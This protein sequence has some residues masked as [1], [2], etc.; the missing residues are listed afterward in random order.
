MVLRRGD[1]GKES[2]SPRGIVST[3]PQ[4]VVGRRPIPFRNSVV[5][6]GRC[7]QRLSEGCGL[8]LGDEGETLGKNKR[9]RHKQR[10]AARPAQDGEIHSAL[11]LNTL[12][13]SCHLF[14][15]LQTLSIHK[16]ESIV[17]GA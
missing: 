7:G 2:R 12:N 15:G 9:Q 14:A 4:R 5:L 8:C 16:L 17:S 3:C 1:S 10:T 11:Y 13:P 6:R